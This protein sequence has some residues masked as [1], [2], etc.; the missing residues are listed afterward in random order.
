MWKNVLCFV[1]RFVLQSKK[2]LKFH[3]VI[4]TTLGMLREAFI[5]H[6]KLHRLCGDLFIKCFLSFRHSSPEKMTLYDD[7]SL[8]CCFS[9]QML[10]SWGRCTPCVETYLRITEMWSAIQRPTLLTLVRISW[11]TGGCGAPCGWWL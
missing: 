5:F 10:H 4:C 1:F 3:V 9:S 11:A 8:M 6:R 2:R 7:K